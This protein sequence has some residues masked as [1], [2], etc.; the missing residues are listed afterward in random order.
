MASENKK[1]NTHIGPIKLYYDNENI[2]VV[3]SERVRETTLEQRSL[4]E[5]VIK[6]HHK[7]VIM[8]LTRISRVSDYDI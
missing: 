7:Y 4:S 6:I 3:R 1:V 2:M 8:K 5:H